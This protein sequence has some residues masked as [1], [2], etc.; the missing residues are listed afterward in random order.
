M[1][2]TERKMSLSWGSVAIIRY[3]TKLYTHFFGLR[4]EEQI[5]KLEM[6]RSS[7]GESEMTGTKQRQALLLLKSKKRNKK[8]MQD[9]AMT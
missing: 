6:S 3:Q 7:R 8:H 2:F 1:N 4:T 9:S 5:W